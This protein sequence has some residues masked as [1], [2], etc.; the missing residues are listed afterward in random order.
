MRFRPPGNPPVEARIVDQHHGI[1]PVVAKVAVGDAGQVQKLA[2]ICQ[3]ARDPHDGQAGQII[4]QL[5]AG[6]GHPRSAKAD[7]LGLGR[8]PADGTNEVGAMQVAAR[9]AGREKDSHASFERAS[10]E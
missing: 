1:G 10:E 8:S 2:Q 3:H 5:A 9:F 6:L 4:V 7:E